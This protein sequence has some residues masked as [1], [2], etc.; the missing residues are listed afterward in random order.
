MFGDA[1]SL[2]Q[3]LGKLDLAPKSNGWVRR[4][5][6][7]PAPDRRQRMRRVVL[8]A[9]LGV[10]GDRWASLEPHYLPAQVT[11][12]RADVIDT[13]AAASGAA[14]YESGDNLFID[15]DLSIANLPV[16]SRLAI[17]TAVLEVTA[18]PHRGC[19]KF[20][21]RF[22]ADASRAIVSPQGLAE[23]WRGVHLMVV[24]DGVAECGSAVSV[25]S[26]PIHPPGRTSDHLQAE[27]GESR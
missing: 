5:L 22:G 26:R 6:I 25:L 9:E 3:R 20:R 23:R 19:R 14:W 21:N 1:D 24:A 13:F 27:L 15:L 17:G 11:A 18:D 8:S 2:T 16:G 12:T 4:L 10:K 7:R